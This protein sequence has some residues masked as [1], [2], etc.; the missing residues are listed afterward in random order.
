MCK[1]QKEF[2]IFVES[3]DINIAVKNAQLLCIYENMRYYFRTGNKEMTNYYQGQL[4]AI[5]TTLYY[6]S[7]IN[8]NQYRTFCNI[9]RLAV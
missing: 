3:L 5:Y 9:S 8:D 1:K 7:L 4:S 6:Q 2:E